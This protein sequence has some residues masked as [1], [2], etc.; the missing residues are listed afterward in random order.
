[1][2]QRVS[3]AKNR[4]LV[5]TFCQLDVLRKL[6]I[7]SGHD[8]KVIIYDAQASAPIRALRLAMITWKIA[9]RPDS[10]SLA[11]ACDD[12]ILRYFTD[13]TTNDPAASLLAH[14][15]PVYTVVFSGDGQVMVSGG[16][17]GK[18]VIWRPIDGS[19]QWEI[20]RTLT[21]HTSMISDVRFSRTGYQL[22]SCGHDGLVVIWDA[23][24]GDVTSEIVTK[25]NAINAIEFIGSNKIV[26]GGTAKIISV[27]N[28]TSGHE[29][30]IVSKLHTAP[31]HAF[32]QSTGGD[33]LASASLDGYVYIWTT[34]GLALVAKITTHDFVFSVVFT[35]DGS[36]VVAGTRDGRVKEYSASTGKIVHKFNKM[37]SAVHGIAFSTSAQTGVF[38]ITLPAVKKGTSGK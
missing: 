1:M 8:G 6:F 13:I 24:L 36:C 10:N 23:V 9:M 5:H 15:G 2:A 37:Y 25:E 22:A 29:E 14:I 30:R 17:D 7:A 21:R 27:W 34:E 18:V 33:R 32:A 11:I 26:T 19:Q 31:I 16:A 38:N 20:N 12:G 4:C 28:L 3:K 35:P